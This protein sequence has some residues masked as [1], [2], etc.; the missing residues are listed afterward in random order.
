MD[1]IRPLYAV[2]TGILGTLVGGIVSHRL[3]VSRHRKEQHEQLK[4]RLVAEYRRLAGKREAAGIH[5]LTMAGIRNLTT[6]REVADLIDQIINYGYEGPLCAIR[7]KAANKDLA[8]FF[9]LPKERGEDG[10]KHTAN[11]QGVEQARAV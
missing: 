9:A 1:G 3:A 7:S 5:G 4:E 2:A 6:H 10:L 11:A 8:R